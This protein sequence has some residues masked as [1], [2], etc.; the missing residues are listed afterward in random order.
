[1]LN[2]GEDPQHTVGYV[3]LVPRKKDTVISLPPLSTWGRC[4]GT[5]YIEKNSQEGE[6]VSQAICCP[7]FKHGKNGT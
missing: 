3:I 2:S 7:E 6:A 1:M 5:K 4:Q